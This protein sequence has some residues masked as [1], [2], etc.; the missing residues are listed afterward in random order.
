MGENVH[1]P[2]LKSVLPH[3]LFYFFG[4]YF[5]SIGGTILDTSEKVH[6]PPFKPVL[7]DSL[8]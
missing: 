2:S 4:E 7:L 6:L 5:E 1:W 8:F 3:S